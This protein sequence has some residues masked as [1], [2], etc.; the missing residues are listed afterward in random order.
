MKEVHIKYG[1]NIDVYRELKDLFVDHAPD[2][3][4]GLTEEEK[5]TLEHMFDFE[6]YTFFVVDY[7]KV[8]VTEGGTVISMSS[9]ADLITGT[10][11][12]IKEY[13]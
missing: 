13:T 9:L 6:D 11:D 5:I 1:N 7:E 4:D 12:A 2:F 8:I 10:R 3:I